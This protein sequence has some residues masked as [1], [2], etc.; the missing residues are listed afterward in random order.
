MRGQKMTKSGK[1]GSVG[2]DSTP[3]KRNL[4]STGG[5]VGYIKALVL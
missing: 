4:G 3:I 5:S 2:P 1:K